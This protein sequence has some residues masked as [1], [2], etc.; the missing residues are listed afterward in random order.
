MP[1]VAWV[2]TGFS[3]VEIG[4]CSVNHCLLGVWYMYLQVFDEVD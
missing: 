2:I 1:M 3:S 4:K